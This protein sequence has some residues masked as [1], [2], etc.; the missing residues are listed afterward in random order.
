M[1][2]DKAL[3]VY[4]YILY[5]NAGGFILRYLKLVFK[6]TS[7]PFAIS[8]TPTVSKYDLW[9]LNINLKSVVQLQI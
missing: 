4:L 3:S 2:R 1:H 6:A 9:W 7:H 5:K 8:T